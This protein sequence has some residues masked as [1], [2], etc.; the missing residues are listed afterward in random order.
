M[1]IFIFYDWLTTKAKRTVGRNLIPIFKKVVLKL[2][3]SFIIS[4]MLVA[5]THSSWRYGSLC[6]SQGKKDLPLMLEATDDMLIMLPDFCASICQHKQTQQQPQH[7]TLQ[8]KN[9][10]SLKDLHLLMVCRSILLAIN[11]NREAVLTV[12]R[13]HYWECMA[14][15]HTHWQEHFP[16]GLP[17]SIGTR[18][19]ARPRRNSELNGKVMNINCYFVF[20]TLENPYFIWHIFV[21]DLLWSDTC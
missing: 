7:A 21:E 4:A 3:V 14:C 6:D 13:S 18:A 15:L 17:P 16:G 1:K 8:D 11:M 5:K 19:S 20:L 12:S 9:R 10:T 2:Y